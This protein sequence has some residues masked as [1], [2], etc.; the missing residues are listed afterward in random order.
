MTG[1]LV[2]NP[3]PQARLAKARPR[4]LRIAIRLSP[5]IT[6]DLNT[7]LR[8]MAEEAQLIVNEQLKL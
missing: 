4:Q 5:Y 3:L 2:P 6:I 8:Q 1:T 7:A